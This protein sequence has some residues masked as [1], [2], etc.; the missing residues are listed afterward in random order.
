MWHNFE[1][2]VVAHVFKIIVKSKWC[3]FGEITEM[4]IVEKNQ[5]FGLEDES[6]LLVHD[7]I[8]THINKTENGYYI[9]VKDNNAGIINDIGEFIFP[10]SNVRIHFMENIF[11][12]KIKNKDNG[13]K[14]FLYFNKW[15]KTVL[16][17]DGITYCPMPNVIL[18]K[19][20]DEYA[21]MDV[22]F[23]I[24]SP[25]YPY[26]RHF[27]F[28]LFIYEYGGK[29][30]VLQINGGKRVVTKYEAEYESVKSL[31]KAV[32]PPKKRRSL[33]DIQGENDI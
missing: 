33:K 5:L 8:Y 22:N 23:H 2:L 25:L 18:A 27:K 10:C 30:G 29:Y 17:V 7:C 16:D 13:G 4:N 26:I 9:V 3:N 6:G 20:D 15:I 12:F 28:N 1:L 31:I 24:I 19:K 14:T 21:I 11:V 32:F